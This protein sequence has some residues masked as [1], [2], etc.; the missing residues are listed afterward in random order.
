MTSVRVP[1]FDQKNIQMYIDELKVWQ[2]VTMVE[3]KKQ[4]PLAWMSLPKNDPSNIK[5]SISD[6]IGIEDLSKDDGMDKLIAAMKKA[7]QEE[8]EIEAS[9]KWK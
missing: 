3:K 9:T 2:F 4:G 6:S 1:E 8:G 5:Q 7:F